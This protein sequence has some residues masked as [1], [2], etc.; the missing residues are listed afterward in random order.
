MSGMGFPPGGGGGPP[1]GPPPGM[2]MGGP[3]PNGMPQQHQAPRQVA[4]SPCPLPCPLAPPAQV[5]ARFRCA[6]AAT[7]VF[8]PRGR[9]EGP[10]SMRT[11]ISI[12]VQQCVVAQGAG[13]CVGVRAQLQRCRLDSAA[14]GGIRA[15]VH[16]PHTKREDTCVRAC[17][18]I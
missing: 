9:P 4:R 7:R 2:G 10:C 8:P 1:G 5:A 11:G 3:P 6:A 15:H 16:G 17:L 18:H 12:C 14:R 13:R